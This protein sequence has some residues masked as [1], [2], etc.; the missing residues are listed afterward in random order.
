MK[1]TR[2]LR[3]FGAK[4]SRPRTPEN[5]HFWQL[6]KASNHSPNLTGSLA[7]RDRSTA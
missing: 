5:E 1:M 6:R 4:A 3:S 7:I 2:K